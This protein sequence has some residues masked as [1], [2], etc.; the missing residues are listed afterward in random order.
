MIATVIPAIRTPRGVDAFD[1]LVPESMSVGVGDLVRIPFR[2][3]NIVGVVSS[4][5]HEVNANRKLKPLDSSYGD[6]KLD[7][8]TVKLLFAAAARSISSPPNVLH[9]WLG[10]L[11]KKAKPASIPARQSLLLPISEQHLMT[12]HWL[13]QN[14]IVATAKRA[15]SEK[16]RVLVITPW[17]SR[18]VWLAERI[19]AEL[20]TS[21]RSAGDRFRAWSGF[22]R[23][24]KHALVCTRIGA[25]LSTEADLV[26]LDEPENDDHKQDEL[27]PRYDARWIAEQAHELGASLVT[28]GLTPRLQDPPPTAHRPPPTISTSLVTV[29][30][31]RADWSPISGLQRRTVNE[32]EHARDEKRPIFIIHPI[33]GDRAR[34]RCADCGW[35]AECERCGAGLTAGEN[36]LLCSRCHFRTEMK[37]TCP[38][39]GGTDLSR[40]R[41][42]RN[43][44]MR[45]LV[46]HGYMTGTSV[47]P[48]GEWNDKTDL[49]PHALV[50]VTDLALLPGAGEDIR[51]KER[52]I[53]A[54]RR[55]ADICASSDASL[56]IQ[57]DPALIA[58]AKAWLTSEG[59]TQALK[60]EQLERE[61]FQLPPSVRLVKCIL[62]GT[63]DDMKRKVQELTFAFNELRDAK[64]AGPFPV[65][66]RTHSRLP[67][68]IAHVM[69]PADTKDDV[70]R[71][72]LLPV[73]SL[74]DLV[75]LDPIAF[76]E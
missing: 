1:Y 31:H 18:A 5:S 51:R 19:G 70:I 49:P 12:N 59:C 17:A 16:K 15:A 6:L 68:W 28:F 66:F 57:S 47:L 69:V 29:D 11:P 53:V 36:G 40:A 46:A 23:G 71:K 27:A 63:E 20:L 10:T 7:K 73:L 60:R 72:Y 50:I 37:M 34:L 2:T 8:R 13:G 56:V 26:I 61:Q 74:D 43:R 45:D 24:T 25:W 52:L 32:L 22:I 76:F 4:V 44:I 65:L 41:P 9:A 33:H 38:S 54:F 75:D 58:D 35:L 67:R 62:K 14:G 39:C 21:Q 3:S 42:G 30:I 64:T 55:I 48:L